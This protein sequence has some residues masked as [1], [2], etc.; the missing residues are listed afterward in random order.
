MKVKRI[1][2]A[3]SGN[4]LLTLVSGKEIE[5]SRRQGQLLKKMISL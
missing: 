4:Y 3:V 1:D 5:A 2:E